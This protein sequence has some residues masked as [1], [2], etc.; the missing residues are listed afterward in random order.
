[1]AAIFP[2]DKE[3][4]KLGWEC[5]PKPENRLG[6][7]PRKKRFAKNQPDYETRKSELQAGWASVV[8]SLTEARRFQE[9]F[10]AAIPI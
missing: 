3:V 10:I 8:T 9:E 2:K 4:M 7:Q 5:Y 6:Q 1:M